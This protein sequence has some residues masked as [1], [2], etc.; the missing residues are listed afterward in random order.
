MAIQELRF[1]ERN[2]FCTLESQDR[3]RYFRHLDLTLC[4]LNKYLETEG[5]KSVSDRQNPKFLY[6][7]EVYERFDLILQLLNAGSIMNPSLEVSLSSGFPSEGAVS[8]LLSMKK[9]PVYSLKANK[10]DAEEEY[11]KDADL[12]AR[13]LKNAQ[14]S[15]LSGEPAEIEARFLQKREYEHKVLWANRPNYVRDLG[16]NGNLYGI[17]HTP[18]GELTRHTGYWKLHHYSPILHAPL[19]L[20]IK[21]DSDMFKPDRLSGSPLI[22]DEFK[23]SLKNLSGLGSYQMWNALQLRFPEKVCEILTFIPQFYYSAQQ[24]LRVLQEMIPSFPSRNDLTQRFGK[25]LSFLV[26]EYS[27]IR[28]NHKETW[29]KGECPAYGINFE[30]SY[31]FLSHDPVLTHFLGSYSHSPRQHMSGQPLL[32]AF[33]QSF[34]RRL[35][36]PGLDVWSFPEGKRYE[37]PLIPGRRGR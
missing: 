28:L 19:F 7:N 12:I 30:K 20:M 14:E 13:I 6:L 25:D 37:P 33:R 1:S 22:P 16:Y 3:E 21:L 35:F 4:V 5:K 31:S 26:C 27:F 15:I 17:N 8:R 23:D 29:V 34:M 11:K 18:K 24:D 10:N 36:S 2:S 32:A 9:N